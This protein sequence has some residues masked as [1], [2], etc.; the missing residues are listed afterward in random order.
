MPALGLG[1]PKYMSVK[2]CVKCRALI[3]LLRIFH[4]FL[5]FFRPWFFFALMGTVFF[6]YSV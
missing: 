4:T 5:F 1:V 3:F 6:F 2:D